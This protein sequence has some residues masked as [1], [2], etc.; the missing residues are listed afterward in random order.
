MNAPPAPP[1]P[2]RPNRKR[3]VSAPVDAVRLEEAARLCAGW[4]ADGGPS[5]NIVTVNA[6]TVVAM[7]DDP[8]L[9]EAV[10]SA[11]LVVAD[12]VSIS[13]AARALGDP[14]PG[15]VPGIELMGKLL[16]EA[17][18]QGHACYFLGARPEVI[19][20]LLAALPSRYPGLKVAG[21]HHGY[22]DRA[23]TPEIVAAI[24]KTGAR[25]LFVAFGQPEAEIWCHRHGPAT[26]A[27]LTM[28]VG[29]SFDVLSGAIRRSPVWMQ[30][31]GLEWLWRFALEPRKRFRVIFVE[32]PRFLGLVLRTRLAGHP[33]RGR[34]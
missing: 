23:K 25:L 19:D 2:P 13:L 1:E 4:C 30:R 3:I 7:G 11:A 6:K 12:G 14:L 9:K 27:S 28:S 8:A 24:R 32:N 17:A 15:R 29:G 20:N 18:R 33:P 10:D 5:R 16:E 31:A 34:S 21:A 22:F 26:G